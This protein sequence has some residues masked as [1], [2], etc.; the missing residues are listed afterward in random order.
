MA[1]HRGG[2]AVVDFAAAGVSERKVRPVVVISND[3]AN[4][5]SGA[6]TVV[7]ITEWDEKKARLP[8]CVELPKGVGGATK[9][10]I[11]HCGQIH[12][13]KRQFMRE[14]RS[15]I[16]AGLLDRADKALRLHLALG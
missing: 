10:S 9:R 6:L 4:Q 2:V 5:F 7:L 15:T 1:F 11:I 16:P 12:T 8:V 3:I 13:V 14:T